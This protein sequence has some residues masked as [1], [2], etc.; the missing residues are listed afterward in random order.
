M[1]PG[2]DVFL[3][4]NAGLVTLPSDEEYSALARDLRFAARM[5]SHA[6]QCF[7]GSLSQDCWGGRV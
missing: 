3:A 4:H 7:G 2:F 5:M 6:D 1:Y